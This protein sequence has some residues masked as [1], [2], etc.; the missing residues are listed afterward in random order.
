MVEKAERMDE[1][2]MCI[3]VIADRHQGGLL[4]FY[5]SVCQ[6]LSEQMESYQSVS[7]YAVG[8]G[9]F[10][11][12]AKSGEFHLP[13]RVKFGEGIWTIA[14][15]RGNLVHEWMNNQSFVVAPFYEGH[16]LRGQ[17]LVVSQPGMQLDEEDTSFFCELASL[18]ASKGRKWGFE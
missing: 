7:V 16:H 10:Y 6:A 15:V 12:A 3:G 13:E 4:S 11:C 8:R 18:F 1:L 2:R 17:L 9:F 14:A 5:Q